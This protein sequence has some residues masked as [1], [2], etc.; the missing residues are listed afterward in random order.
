MGKSQIKSH[1]KIWNILHWRFNFKSAAYVTPLVKM[2]LKKRYELNC[3]W[4]ISWNISGQKN[5]EILHHSWTVLVNLCWTRSSSNLSLVY[6]GETQYSR[7]G[8]TKVLYSLRR[9]S[10]DLYDIVLPVKPRALLA[11]E[12]ACWHCI[13]GFIVSERHP[14]LAPSLLFLTWSREG[15]GCL[16]LCQYFVTVLSLL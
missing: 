13:D 14:G 7:W 12:Y 16:H 15:R 3:A 5:H 6:H 1:S 8:R 4:N 9:T 10:L 11:L 2:L